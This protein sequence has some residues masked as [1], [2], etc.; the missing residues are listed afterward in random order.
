MSSTYTEGFITLLRALSL[1]EGS[2]KPSPSNPLPGN[3]TTNTIVYSNFDGSGFFGTLVD[4]T[5]NT[6]G[7]GPGYMTATSNPAMGVDIITDEQC[8]EVSYD[9]PQLINQ[10]F[11]PFDPTAAAV[12]RYRKQQSVNLGSW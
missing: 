2:Y 3:G 8:P 11:A 4:P 10:F 6:S 7:P 12:Y 9:S 5:F 1:V